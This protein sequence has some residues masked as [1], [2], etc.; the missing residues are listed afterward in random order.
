M[1][2]VRGRNSCSIDRLIYSHW[3]IIS[4]ISICRRL[5]VHFLFDSWW[6]ESS[7]VNRCFSSSAHV[8]SNFNYRYIWKHKGMLRWLW[9]DI[10]PLIGKLFLINENV[11]DI[12]YRLEAFQK[13]ISKIMMLVGSSL[14][15]LA[16]I[17]RSDTQFGLS[18]S[19]EFSAVYLYM[20]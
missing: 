4:R 13:Y 19:E 2:N 15:K 8:C 18:L 7:V 12:K 14:T 16:P 17:L 10:E 11:L 3:T 1:W 20:E 6:N 9:I 5:C